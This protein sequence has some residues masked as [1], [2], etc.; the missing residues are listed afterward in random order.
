MRRFEHGWLAYKQAA[1]PELLATA[2][3]VKLMT[4]LG[5]DRS[6]DQ[7]NG[8]AKSPIVGRAVNRLQDLHQD[9]AD[10]AVVSE[11]GVLAKTDG[12]YLALVC[13]RVRY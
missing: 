11:P 6:N 8:A 9:L 1:N 12:L 2:K 4:A 5:Y 7:L 3:P 13:H 10:C